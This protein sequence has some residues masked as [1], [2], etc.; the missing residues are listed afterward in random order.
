MENE[1][2]ML[3]GM[4]LPEIEYFN[5]AG[6]SICYGQLMSG[7]AVIAGT[8]MLILAPSLFVGNPVVSSN[9]IGK[10]IA[11]VAEGINGIGLGISESGKMGMNFSTSFWE[12]SGGCQQMTGH[13]WAW[14]EVDLTGV[15]E[16]DDTGMSASFKAK[17]MLK[18][19]DLAFLDKLLL[20]APSHAGITHIQSLTDPAEATAFLSQVLETDVSFGIDG[21]FVVQLPLSDWSDGLFSD[22]DIV[23]GSMS[24]LLKKEGKEVGIYVA[25]RTGGGADPNLMSNIQTK[26]LDKFQVPQVQSIVGFLGKGVGAVVDASQSAGESF[27]MYMKMDCDWNPGALSCSNFAFGFKFKASGFEA[28]IQR[29][30]NGDFS[31]CFAI[32]SVW[33][34][35]GGGLNENILWLVEELG[36]VIIQVASEIAD[37]LKEGYQVVTKEVAKLQKE[38]LKKGEVVVEEVGKGFEDGATAV[39]QWSEQTGQGVVKGVDTAVGATGAAVNTAGNAIASTANTA[40]QAIS[41]GA[42]TAVAAVT[43]IIPPPPPRRRR[44]R[45]RRKGWVLW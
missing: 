35:C 11:Q 39:G 15:L 43:N 23:L 13:V 1:N 38:A 10:V 3:F 6:G 2:Y 22:R 4:S 44:T 37:A 41:S 29:F 14:L 25:V 33:D 36:K 5:F 31:F 20:P 7:D 12:C 32:K 27:D 28:S 24:A 21:Q 45:R 16:L 9:P 17:C 8:G 30:G 34:S 19:G 40:G 42:D 18:L 26:I